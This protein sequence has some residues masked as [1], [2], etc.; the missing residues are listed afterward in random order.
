MEK[1]HKST[2][3]IGASS[4]IGAALA[5]ELA[6]TQSSLCLSARSVAGLEEVKMQLES[7]LPVLIL[8]CDVSQYQEL[9]QVWQTLNTHWSKVDR[10]IFMAGVYS[11]SQLTNVSKE[12]ID[13]SI[14]I[15]LKS[16]F[17]LVNVILPDFLKQ[18]TGKKPQLIFCASVAGY[19]GLPMAQPYAATKA[20]LINLVE[21][22]RTEVGHHIDVKLINPG[23][24]ETRLTAKNNFYMP[25]KISTEQA[26]QAIFNALESKKF[27]IHFPKRFTYIMKII[28]WLP[29]TW[30]FRWFS[31]KY[32]TGA[33]ANE[34]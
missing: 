14:D 2:W 29:D 9:Q 34:K 4:G 15:N 22:L 12:M 10:I 8:P 32:Q 21:T 28:R 5:I 17:Y 19:R 31:K 3:I 16:A 33:S 26:A 24:V 11:P 18:K 25:A 20:G 23:F 7:D 1:D 30:Y 13:E 27:E 6:K